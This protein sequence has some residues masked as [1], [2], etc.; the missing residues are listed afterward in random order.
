VP[1]VGHLDRVRGTPAG[2]VGVGTGTITGDDLHPRVRLEPDG[3][4]GGRALGQQIDDRMSFLVD[5]DR[6]VRAA[7]L[8]GP[9][10][11]AE[12]ANRRHFWE[13][14]AAH[15]PQERCAT[16][17]ATQGAAQARSWSTP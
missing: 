4:R 8:A 13:R 3:E 7:S 10:V 1:A 12:H 15:Q 14:Q 2:P 17:G 6:P 9:V 16:D 5:Q 11:D